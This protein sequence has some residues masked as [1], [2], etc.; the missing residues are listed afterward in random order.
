VISFMNMKGGVGK[1]TLAVN[2]AYGLAFFHDLD[3]LIVDTDPQFNATQYLLDDDV[4]LQHVSDPALGT[5]RDVFYPKRP[6]A[7]N[8]VAGSA[9]AINRTRMPL[10]DCTLNIEVWGDRGRLDLMP[11]T[12]ALM[13]IE[14]SK[15]GTENK[16]RAYI[17]EK[18]SHYDY[19]IIDCP[20][21]ISVF[22]QAAI[23]ASDKYLVPVKPDPLSVIGLPLLERWLSD[24]VDDAGVTVDS[25]GLVF[26]MVRGNAPKRMKEVMRELR[27]QRGDQVFDNHLSESTYVAQSVESHKPVFI[28]KKNSIT[29][30]QMQRITEEFLDRT[31]GD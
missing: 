3:V 10:K 4:Y 25:V 21:T 1:T 15:R 30:R 13:D 8:T 24:Y 31:S 17:R 5:V 6:G 29:A 22:T 16:L 14:M 26:T 28:T 23:L 2:I 20:P 27:S 11:S 19:V 7:V 12:L 9:K 18:C